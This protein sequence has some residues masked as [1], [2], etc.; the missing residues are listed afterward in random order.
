MKMSALHPAP[1][2][3]NEA[4]K[5]KLNMIE[6]SIGALFMNLVGIPIFM[7]TK[8]D[9]RYISLV[10]II[11][12]CLYGVT[13]IFNAYL[14]WKSRQR[15]PDIWANFPSPAIQVGNKFN[16]LPSSS[17]D[18]TQTSSPFPSV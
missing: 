9:L 15:S 18:A 3:N 14:Y 6:S 12:G 10:L 17:L 11:P 2:E 4:Q 1:F 7:S 8:S 5:R 13:A 16:P